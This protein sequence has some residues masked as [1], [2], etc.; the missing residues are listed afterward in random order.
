V[1][2]L[3]DPFPSSSWTTILQPPNLE[4]T[5]KLTVTG[6]NRDPEKLFTDA[7]Q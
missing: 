4:S 5:L 6:D 7:G 1:N 2:G 3:E